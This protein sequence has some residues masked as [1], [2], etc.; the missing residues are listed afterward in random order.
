MAEFSHD[1]VADGIQQ[2]IDAFQDQLEGKIIGIKSII[3]ELSN[4]TE[5]EID[6]PED[7]HGVIGGP[8][9]NPNTVCTPLPGGLWQC[10]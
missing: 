5:Q 6:L 8:G 1:A 2:L 9:P 10:I 7:V 4:E 3:F